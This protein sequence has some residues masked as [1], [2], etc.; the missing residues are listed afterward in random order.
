MN[1]PIIHKA[2]IADEI[3]RTKA[4]LLRA[5]QIGVRQAAILYQ[6]HPSTLWRAKNKVS[7]GGLPFD[8][9]HLNPGAA[10]R[11]DE[12]RLKWALGYMA[13]RQG[14]ALA[15]C[16]KKGFFPT[17][18]TCADGFYCRS[19]LDRSPSNRGNDHGPDDR[20][21]RHLFPRSPWSGIPS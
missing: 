16:G 1:T 11:V 18:R 15:A 20:Y 12:T 2:T 8:R 13:D 6:K 7:E 5:E 3:N 4:M 10:S 19:P 17:A 14:I 9:R 21:H